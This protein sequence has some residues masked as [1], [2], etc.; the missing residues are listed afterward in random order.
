M[1]NTISE[2]LFDNQA[3]VVIEP[4]ADYR[5][6]LYQSELALIENVSHKR[7]LEFSTGRD[8]AHQALH[9]LGY[10]TCPI[11]KGTHREPLWP[12]KIVG[13]ISHCRDLA[14]AVVT[15]QHRVRSVGFDIENR[16]QLDSNIA[17]HICTPTEKDW[18]KQLEHTQQNLGLLKIFSLKEAV[19]KC[20][21]Q[22]TGRALRFQECQ[23]LPVL[24]DG[25]AEACIKTT[26]IKTASGLLRLHFYTDE[27]HI[28]SGA[29]WRYQH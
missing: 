11:L 8:C 19:F 12:D 22:A 23:V 24:A 25:G 15:D 7:M 18:I 4:I 29:I 16:K 10:E 20:V 26:D 9:Q 28:Y 1:Q 3:I 27:A 21:Y 2:R 6:C 17:R 13:S 5:H 14:G